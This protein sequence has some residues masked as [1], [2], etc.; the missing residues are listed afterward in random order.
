MRQ[1]GMA[2]RWAFPLAL[3][4]VFGLAGCADVSEADSN[5]RDEPVSIEE[6]WVRV[7]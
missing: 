1:R 4:A 7:S 6:S 3:V 5:A 2:K